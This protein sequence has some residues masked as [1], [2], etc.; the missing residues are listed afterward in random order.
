MSRQRTIEAPETAWRSAACRPAFAAA[1]R[2]GAVASS[3]TTLR[4]VLQWQRAVGNRRVA[5]WIQA[6]RLTPEGHL[7]R[8][9]RQLN[10]GAVNDRY[11]QEAE[12]LAGRVSRKPAASSAPMLAQAKCD[13]CSREEALVE[14]ESASVQ[15]KASMET[16]KAALSRDED[17]IDREM[18][19]SVESR[20]AQSKGGGESLS[21][22][23]RS[24][25]ETAFG[26]D[27]SPVRVHTN[28][29]AVQMS[30][31]LGAKAFTHGSD[32]YFNANR[33]SPATTFGKELL[34]HELTHVLQQSGAAVRP[35]GGNGGTKGNGAAEVSQVSKKDL[36]QLAPNVTALNG[37]AEMAADL[38][39]R[40]GL[41]ATAARGTVIDWSFQGANNGAVLGGGTG[42]TNT[43]T[44]P[45]GSTGGAITVRAA[46]HAN[47]AAD[48]V[49]LNINL[50]QVQQPTFAFAPAMPAFAPANTMDSS[51]CN[52]TATAAAVTAPAAR[53]L[54]WSIVGN[55]L[56]ATIGPATGAVIPSATQT[57]NIR[58][59][60]TDNA[61]RDARNEQALT[62]QGHPT[63]INTT[64]IVAGGFP[65]P[66]ARGGPYGA[67]YTHAFKGSG[68]NIANVMVTERV[69][70]GNGPF[71]CGGLPVVPGNLNAPAGVL[72]DIIG[73]PSGLINANN[74]LPSPP[75][76][77]LPQVMDTPQIL[78]WRSDQ[79]S[80]GPAAPP[81]AAPA[82]HW[83]PFVNVPIKAT[84]LR[85][86]GNLFFQT[87]DNGVSTPLEPYVG[88]ALAAPGAPAASAC[89][90]GE[91][92]SNMTFS[93]GTVGADGSP[94]STLAATVQVRPGGNQLTWSFPG[95]N[96]G[97]NI[98][99]QGNPALFSAGTIAGQVRV[100][101]ALT[102]TPGCFTEGW[103]KMQEVEIGPS[104][105]FSPG[106]VRAGA[107]TRATVSTTPGARIVVWSITGPAL[108]TAIAANPDNSATITAGAAVG[109]ITIRATDQ[110][111]ATRFAEASLVI[112]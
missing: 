4:P 49:D 1:S 41:T 76:P 110:R 28:Q 82:D 6:R 36:L 3:R 80:V 86:G 90:A 91:R 89:G 2:S 94:L 42:R 46:D 25:M 75:N 98:V 61:V 32:I 53:P 88:V 60:A 63:G 7:L 55:G 44:A 43:L 54:T 18:A 35:P 5:Q 33:Y 74:F 38:G 22:S 37:P 70:C 100:R 27:F 19:D 84:L 106:T 72:Q 20:L 109:R 68:G 23:L 71:A 10:L 67:I 112:S 99:A 58:V 108:G 66:A 45:A 15:R 69:F 107:T 14:R 51:V 78:Y 111:D 77:G 48:F 96:F 103:L 40:A 95:P 29:N 8:L 52:N 92:L 11:E 64:S 50:V 47:A 65:M 21:Q 17:A 34:A 85:R 13:A 31:D 79:C 30:R 93:P 101:A 62:I 81:V 24:Q 9:E 56:G 57:G 16:P 97:A 59:R 87:S 12:R 104:I 73:T 26:A 102:A 39:K 105:R 83:V